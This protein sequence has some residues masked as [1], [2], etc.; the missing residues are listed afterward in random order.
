MKVRPC[1]DRQILEPCGLEGYAYQLDPFIGCKHHCHYYAL[2]QAETDWTEEILVHRDLVGRLS[3]ELS[4][5][6]PQPIYM[7]WNADPYQP[8]EG[9][10]RQ[11]RRVLEL[12]AQQ[13]FSVCILTKSDLVTRDIDLLASMP[14]SSVG[15]SIAFRDER[16]RRLFEA[17]A[18]PNQR[19][20]KAL[21]KLKEAGIKTYG[22]ICPV[23]PF[24]TDVELLVETVAPYA[25]SVSIYALSVAAEA[26]RNWQNI[27]GILDRH[28]PEL[29][30]Q[31]RQIAFSPGHPYWTELR[32]RLQEFQVAK[33]LSITICL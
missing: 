19:R 22:L 33:R 11:A 32:R 15:I 21:K 27:R 16:T 1:S 30:A 5:L 14:G 4:A 29:T 12:L 28:F 10:H 6:E 3:Q 13:G 31:Y 17:E 2:N 20:I 8:V 23:M 25:D 24:I 9:T 18:P 26:D 7:G